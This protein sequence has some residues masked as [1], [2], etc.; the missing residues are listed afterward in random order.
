MLNIKIASTGL[1]VPPKIQTAAELSSLI[2]RSEEW[3]LSRTGVRERRI[4]EEPMDVMAAKAARE[5]IGDGEA[6]DCIINGSVTPL[7][8]IPD[9]SVF[10]QQQLGY[11]SIPSW[12]THATCLSFL[13]SMMNAA[14]L[15]ESNLYRRILIVS[16]E[17]GTP[18][19]NVNEAESASLFGD[20]AAAVVLEKSPEKSHSGVLDWQMRTWPEGAHYTE[21]RGCGTRKPPLNEETLPTDNLFH[22]KGPKVFRLALTHIS[23]FLEELLGRNNM[24]FE[25]VDHLILHQSS[26]PGMEAFTKLGFEREKIVNIVSEYGNC[27]AAS[28]PMTLATAINENRFKKGDRILIGGTGAGLSIAFALLQW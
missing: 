20:G 25:D 14:A 11:D 19:R 6:P 21:F 10:I 1:Y 16:S 12:S 3:I 26:G 27:I 8:L 7:Q 17:A 2:G 13:V 15:I 28:I 24:A 23:H 4:A 5:A 22:M 9:S 18:W